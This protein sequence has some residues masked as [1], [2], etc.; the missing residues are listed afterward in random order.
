MQKGEGGILCVILFMDANICETQAL[1][2]ESTSVVG[3]D[4]LNS[5]YFL[6]R[7]ECPFSS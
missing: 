4:F 6:S 3:R 2:L 7:K 5:S 1:T